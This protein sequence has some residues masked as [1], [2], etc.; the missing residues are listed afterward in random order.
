MHTLC[1]IGQAQTP[2]RALIAFGIL[3]VTVVLSQ[4]EEEVVEVSGGEEFAVM[5]RDGL[6]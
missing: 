3:V 1:I 2:N 6:A 5:L 4:I